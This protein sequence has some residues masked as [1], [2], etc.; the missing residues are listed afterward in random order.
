M[1]AGA[2]GTDLS[3]TWN[4]TYNP[5]G[6]LTQVSDGS[7]QTEAYQHDPQGDIISQTTGNTAAAA[8]T[9]TY[10]RGLLQTSA[11]SGQASTYNYDPLGRLDTVTGPGGTTEQS[12]TYDGFDNVISNTQGSGSSATTTSYSYDP[13]NR[14]TSQATG[15]NTTSY[16]Y[17][18]LTSQVSSETDPGNITKTYGYT[19]GGT[20]LFQA[21]AGDPTTSLNGTAYYS[22]NNHG[23]VE[24]LT[25]PAGTPTATYG[26][27]AYGSSVAAMFTGADKNAAQPG[28]T[29]IPYDYYRFNA[30]RWDPGSGQYNMGF[31]NYDP[32]LNSFVSRD[33][34]TGAAADMTLTAGSLYAFGDANP[35]SNTE[36]DGHWGCFLPVGCGV[37]STVSSA[38]VNGVSDIFLVPAHTLAGIILGAAPGIAAGQ[39]NCLGCTA[40]AAPPR[41]PIPT[42]PAR[43]GNHNSWLYKAVYYLAPALTPGAVDDEIAAAASRA[44]A[45]GAAR[46]AAAAAAKEAAAS[47]AAKET[48]TA[49]AANAAAEDAGNVVYRALNSQDVAT[50]ARGEGIVAKNPEGEWSLAQHI[51]KGSSR[52]SWANDPWISTT[53]DQGVAEGFNESGSKLGV[54]AINLDRVSSVTA[55]GWRIYPRLPGE[56]GLPYYYSIWQQEVSVFQGTPQEA[57]MGFVK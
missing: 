36:L 19:P 4:D 10:S 14:V 24:A 25:G 13:L 29:A 5:V 2:S 26:Y 32:G 34:Y 30:M 49:A 39:G 38:V 20:R 50:M 54:V 45:T 52:T 46:D 40:G 23:D 53:W 41:N 57:I 22:Y 12:S 11:T 31:R 6:Q 21:T 43:W 16:S 9:Y 42:S 55:E 7:T 28:P 15:T 51:V 37:I 35:I 17:L 3:H 8:A 56:A 1:S 18:G 48:A 33:M 44:A 27:T 47:A